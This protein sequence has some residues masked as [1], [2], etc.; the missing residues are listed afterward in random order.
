MSHHDLLELHLQWLIELRLLELRALPPGL[1][2]VQCDWDISRARESSELLQERSDIL[3]GS[4][5]LG[6]KRT[7]KDRE[8]SARITH[9]VATAVAAM[10]MSSPGGITVFGRHWCPDHRECEAAE[11]AAAE[12]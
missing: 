3:M 4:P 5:Q 9:L 2:A 8:D 1:R 10:A 11:R 7:R 12:R 6:A